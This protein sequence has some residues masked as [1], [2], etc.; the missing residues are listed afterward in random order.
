MPHYDIVY[1]ADLRFTGGTSTA[2]TNELTAARHAGLCV[3]VRPMHAGVLARG[4]LVNGDVVAALSRLKVPVLQRGDS[5]NARLALIYHPSLLNTPPHAP[6]GIRAA[7]TGIVIHHPFRDRLGVA[8]YD[9]EAAIE[10]AGHETGSK[11][12]LL[13][14]GPAVRAGLE[15][16]SADIW[17]RDW[18]NLINVDEWPKAR[19]R[20]NSH[21]LHIGRHSRPDLQK[22]PSPELATLIYPDRAPFRYSMLGVTPEITQTFAPWPARWQALP[23]RRGAAQAFLPDLDL[24]SYYHADHWIEAFGYNVLEALATGLTT[25][26]PPQ[27]ETLF[28]EAAIYA[29]PKDAAATYEKYLADPA[30]RKAQGLLARKI[31]K[32]QFGLGGFGERVAALTTSKPISAPRR[33]KPAIPDRVICVT[34]NGIGVGHLSRQIG[35]ATAMEP[36]AQW[37]FFSLSRAVKFAAESGFCT[38]YRN[39]H[40]SIDI[41]FDTW[42]DWFRGELMEAFAFYQ[43]HAMVFDGNVPYRGMIEACNEFQEV[44]TV[45]VRRGLLRHQN[46]TADKRGHGFHRVIQPGEIVAPNDTAHQDQSIPVLRVPPILS[47]PRKAQLTKQSAR[48]VLGLPKDARIAL[49]QLGSGTNY[50]MNPAREQVLNALLGDRETLVF[51]LISHVGIQDNETQNDRHLRRSL[52]PL[53]KY[54]N[55]FD[56]AISAAGY[57]SFHENIASAIPTLFIPNTAPEM[58][59]QETRARYAARTGWAQTARADDPYGLG[60]ALE[61]LTNL[62]ARSEMSKKMQGISQNWDG[63]TAAAQAITLAM[64]TPAG[65]R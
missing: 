45:W 5:I 40:R 15:T 20:A 31:T 27:F 2:L 6:L 34:S 58:D 19:F 60:T 9:L 38:E 56:F 62:E 52:Y 13:P 51:E 30:A 1:V 35:I 39:F 26:L 29:D 7:Q 50:D 28:G 23:F 44:S 49:L 32:E 3:A 55:A 64:R 18:T 53:F 43:P 36:G 54:L 25:V 10:I 16:Q 22:W 11:P 59:M 12:V 48:Q 24:F 14:V 37:T 57:N 61:R 63:A 4:A 46:E 33:H 8:Q 41:D 17:D 42:N 21:E 65:G 47:V